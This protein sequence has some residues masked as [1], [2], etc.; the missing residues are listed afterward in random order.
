MPPRAQVLVIRNN[1]PIP[2]RVA[3][4]LDRFGVEDEFGADGTSCL[5]PRSAASSAPPSPRGSG[6]SFQ[7]GGGGG[8]SVGGASG[9]RKT[10][11]AR[12]PTLNNQGEELQVRTHTPAVLWRGYGSPLRA[13]GTLSPPGDALSGPAVLWDTTRHNAAPHSLSLSLSTRTDAR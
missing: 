1:T 6:V 12:R 10:T 8:S 11:N 7:G 13:L 5:T 4:G 9:L 2:T 3:L